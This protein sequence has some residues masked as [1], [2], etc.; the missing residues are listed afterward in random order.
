MAERTTDKKGKI[1][2]ICGPTASGKSELA[3]KCASLLNSEI[4][5]A[6]AL[7][8]YRG[9]NIGTAKPTA[10]DRLKIKH[11]LIDVVDADKTFSVGDYKELAR[12][13]VNDL[14]TTGKIP[15]ICG[16]TGF[17]IDSVLYDFSY[18]KSAANLAAREKYMR[19][20]E[21]KGKY[22]VFDILQSV[23]RETAEKLHPNDLKRVVRALEIFESGTKKSDLNDEK[24]PVYDYAAYCMD[25]DR[26]ELYARIDKRVDKMLE[27]GLVAEVEGLI[28]AGITIKNQSMQGIGYKEIYSYLNGDCTLSEAI[29]AIKLNTKH[30]AKR[31]ITYF[32]RLQGLIRLKPD[33]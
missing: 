15:V 22:A 13:V 30:Y 4:I 11:H 12:P 33:N 27:N 31:Q 19:L 9:L 6:D 10:E 16:G 14:I 1:L 17:Y 7:D 25:Y 5:S 21:E 20:A 26:D 18:G 29:A 28:N 23:D 2:I 8:V 3:L 32:K 24:T